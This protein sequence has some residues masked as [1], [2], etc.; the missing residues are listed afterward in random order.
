MN[1]AELNPGTATLIGGPIATMGVAGWIRTPM[2][3]FRTMGSRGRPARKNLRSFRGR[4]KKFP[5]SLMAVLA[6]LLFVAGMASATTV[7]TPGWQNPGR[8]PS[9][10]FDYSNINITSNSPTATNSSIQDMFGASLSTLEAPGR[11]IFSDTPGVVSTSQVSFT[12]DAPVALAGF[13]LFLYEDTGSLNR[14]ATNFELIANGNVI[15]NVALAGVGQSYSMKFGSDWIE[16]SGSFSP[17]IATS[18]QAIFTNNNGNANGI[19][20]MKF[21]GLGSTV[22]ESLDPTPE[23]SSIQL[24]MLTGLV[25]AAFCR[26]RIKH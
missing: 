13:S 12:T 22:S 15:S 7:I 5:F 19:R 14:S 8:S 26:R 20:V 24:V 1:Q 18:F 11:T 17:I 4:G 6:S 10:P 16:V 9:N 25:F 3:K 23:P 21:T 2:E